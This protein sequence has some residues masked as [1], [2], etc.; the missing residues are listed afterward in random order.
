MLHRQM[1]SI[2]SISTARNL[3]DTFLILVYAAAVACFF[4]AREARRA[5]TK[6]ATG[7]P[8]HQT[9]VSVSRLAICCADSDPR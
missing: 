8:A 2:F 9:Y 3:V 5:A 1:M 6:D 4:A 7:R